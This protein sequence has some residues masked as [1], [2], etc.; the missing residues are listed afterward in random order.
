MVM[1]LAVDEVS[2]SG[3]DATDMESGGWSA[4][5]PPPPAAPWR[6]FRA[7][8]SRLSTSASKCSRSCGVTRPRTSDSR[9]N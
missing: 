1:K 9:E 2:V 8:I 4:P 3:Y 7:W 6:A 5:A